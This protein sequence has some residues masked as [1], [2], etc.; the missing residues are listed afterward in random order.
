LLSASLSKL[1]SLVLV[2]IWF[3]SNL[4]T[5]STLLFLGFCRKARS[6]TEQYQGI[7][8]NWDWT[9]GHFELVHLSGYCFCVSTAL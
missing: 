1:L 9:N 2:I 7:N 5:D 4:T 8:P 6:W 3:R